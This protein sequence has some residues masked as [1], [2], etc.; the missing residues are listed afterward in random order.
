MEKVKFETNIPQ[1]L[2]LRF[3]SGRSVVSQIDGS[4]QIMFTC[5]SGEVMYLYPAVA[6]K[7]LDLG[8]KPGEPFVMC[9][10]EIKSSDGS[11]P[12][13]EWQVSRE[14]GQQTV[15]TSA[16][17]RARSSSTVSPAATMS[18]SPTSQQ[19]NPPAKVPYDRALSL[20]L[21]IAG[22]SVRDAESQLAAEGGSVRFDNRDVA[23]LA[24][25]LFIQ[26]ARE[27]YL[28]W[29]SNDDNNAAATPAAQPPATA[30]A[31]RERAV[32]AQEAVRDE[33]IANLQRRVEDSE[34]EIV[35]RL[36]TTRGAMKQ[37]FAAAREAVGETRYAQELALANVRDP[38]ELR[39][40]DRIKDFYRRLCMIAE[41]EAA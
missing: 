38:L 31:A 6:Q 9:K 19:H 13:I 12:R 30:R 4:E 7:I 11:R 5:T 33:K 39:Y 32:A 16:T 36:G 21:V 18:S 34:A 23:A 28:T 10:R 22:R 26:S 2:A 40:F 3:A 37:A 27:G 41:E 17:P 14:A 35:A 25:T 24:T 8:L 29:L 20:F 15:P 1:K